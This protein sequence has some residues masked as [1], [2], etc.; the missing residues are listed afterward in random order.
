[1]SP[2][3]AV[4]EGTYLIRLTYPVSCEEVLFDDCTDAGVKGLLDLDLD[5]SI[6][7][8]GESTVSVNVCYSSA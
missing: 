4:A 5:I 6:S 2:D 8:N 7:A 1:M 3:H